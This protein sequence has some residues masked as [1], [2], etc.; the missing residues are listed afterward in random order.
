MESLGTANDGYDNDIKRTKGLGLSTKDLDPAYPED[1]LLSCVS[2]PLSLGGGNK[3][4]PTGTSRHL[5]ELRS[6]APYI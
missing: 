4:H 6:T 3:S 5:W 1:K 2:Y